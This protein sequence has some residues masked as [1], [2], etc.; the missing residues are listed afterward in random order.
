VP[1][2]D[3]RVR[4]VRHAGVLSGSNAFVTPR[5]WTPDTRPRTP[6]ARVLTSARPERYHSFPSGQLAL[7]ELS[8]GPPCGGPSLSMDPEGRS[9]TGISA[10]DSYVLYRLSYLGVVSGWCGCQM[11]HARWPTGTRLSSLPSPV[12][13]RRVPRRREERQR[14]GW[15]GLA[16]CAKPRGMPGDKPRSRRTRPRRA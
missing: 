5:E 9:R 12:C 7:L 2:Q 4:D 16:D 6:A 14:R 10:V 15:P 1:L 11:A 13:S 8:E 3:E